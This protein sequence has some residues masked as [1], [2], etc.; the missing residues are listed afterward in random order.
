MLAKPTVT[1]SVANARQLL[2][3]G[4]GRG[5]VRESESEGERGRVRGRGRMRGS[6]AKYA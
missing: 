1:D 5:R 6:E 2:H 4:R 3:R